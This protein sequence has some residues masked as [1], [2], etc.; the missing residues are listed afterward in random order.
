M[1]DRVGGLSHPAIA[2]TFILR[3]PAAFKRLVSKAA[4]AGGDASSD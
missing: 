3:T 1:L 4:A 2:S